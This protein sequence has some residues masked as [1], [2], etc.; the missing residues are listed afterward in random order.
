MNLSAE[1]QATHQIRQAIRMGTTH[2]RTHVDVDT[3]I[4]LKNLEGIMAAR[5]KFKDLM[6][7]QIVAFPQSGMLIPA[8]DG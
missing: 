4:G 5:E 2:I 6:T 3:E 7:I 8:G 1:K